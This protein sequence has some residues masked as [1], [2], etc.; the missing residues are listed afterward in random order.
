MRV[1]G[2][3]VP[4]LLFGV[5]PSASASD[6]LTDLARVYVAN[7]TL[8]ESHVPSF[9]RQTG[10]AC[11]ACHYQFLQLTAFGDIPGYFGEAAQFSMSPIEG[12][13]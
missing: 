3:L 1:V 5:A 8:A 9:A 13:Q 12:D 2:W 7:H 6:G 4:A 10:L 11:S